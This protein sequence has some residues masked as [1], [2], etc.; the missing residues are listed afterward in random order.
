MKYKEPTEIWKTRKT[1]KCLF[2]YKTYLE[3][4]EIKTI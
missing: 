3:A 4:I 1:R 2:R